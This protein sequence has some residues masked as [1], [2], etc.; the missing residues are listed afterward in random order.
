[1]KRQ[2]VKMVSSAVRFL[3]IVGVVCALHGVAAETTE[4]INS[5]GDLSA[6]V[7]LGT[8][9]S[10]LGIP[11]LQRSLELS[12]PEVSLVSVQSFLEPIVHDFRRLRRISTSM[13]PKQVRML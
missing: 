11:F 8:T 4:H 2:E 9:K 5:W 10:K 12:Y 3:A 7:I 1:M 6:Q 13:D